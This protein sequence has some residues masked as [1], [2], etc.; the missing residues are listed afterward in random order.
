MILRTAKSNNLYVV[1]AGI[2][3][4]LTGTLTEYKLCLLANPK[5]TSSRR[6][7]PIFER[8]FH[9]LRSGSHSR[10]RQWSHARRNDDQTV[11]IKCSHSTGT[12]SKTERGSCKWKMGALMVPASGE[13]LVLESTSYLLHNHGQARK[14]VKNSDWRPPIRN[15]ILREAFGLAQLSTRRASKVCLSSVS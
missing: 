13:V 9:R 2:L 10:L 5:L 11:T 4:Q 6:F 12:Y 8:A 7:L 3:F 15:P 1:F 14:L